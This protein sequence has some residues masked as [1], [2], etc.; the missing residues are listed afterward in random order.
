MLRPEEDWNHWLKRADAC[1]YRA[2]D[3][4]RDCI[5]LDCDMHPES[6]VA[7]QP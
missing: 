2:K 5:V 4:G 7:A 6:R 3:S 1:L